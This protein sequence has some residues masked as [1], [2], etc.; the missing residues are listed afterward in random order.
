MTY[1]RALATVE[2]IVDV[3]PI[4]DADAIETVKVRGW[5]VVAKKGQFQPGDR[6]IYFE[7][8]S[9]LPIDH[10]EFAFLAPRGTRVQDGVE[11]H[12]LRTAKLRGQVSQGLVIGPYS[13]HVYDLGDDVT[14]MY[15]VTKYEPPIPAEIAGQV[16]GPFPIKYVSKTDAERVQNISQQDYDQ[17]RHHGIWM[18]LEKVDGTSMT[19]ICDEYGHMRV[20]GRNWE[21]KESDNTLWRLAREHIIPHLEVGNYVQAEVYGEG[22]Q[23]NPLGI[24]GQDVAIFNF[25]VSD[26][27]FGEL[28]YKM[29]PEYVDLD[30][31]E[32]IEEAIAQADGIKSLINPERRAE[33]IVWHEA[34]KQTFGSLGLRSCFKVISNQ[35][36]L[37][38]QD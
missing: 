1:D 32:T 13:G 16:A 30:L 2:E 22:I 14:E 38:N 15:G 26:A 10:P 31:P 9:F 23:K 29:A 3:Q 11:G 24:K 18:P 28:V 37:K 36:L 25:S 6:C 35:Y 5:N 21:Y 7:I 34:G 27:A 4:P 8:D 19:V 17:L 33:G 20:C 12:V